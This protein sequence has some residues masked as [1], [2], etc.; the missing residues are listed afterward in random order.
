MPDGYWEG[1]LG[2]VRALVSAQGAKLSAT[3]ST[4]NSRVILAFTALG[5]DATAVAG[6]DLVAPLADMDWVTRQG[7]NGAIF[8]LI[9]ANSGGYTIPAD[10][11]VT[12]QT[13][14][15]KLIAF[16]LDRELGKGTAAAGGWALSGTDPD[17]DITAMALQSLAPYYGQ[18]GYVDLTQAVDRALIRLSGMQLAD[19]GFA[20]TDF[21]GGAPCCESAAQ[22]VIALTAL[23]VDPT[24][25]ARFVKAGG[26]PMTALLGFYQESTGAFEHDASGGGENLMAT[27]QAMLALT[28]YDRLHAGEPA[29]Y[30][31]TD[32]T[33]P[34]TRI[35]DIPVVGQPMTPSTSVDLPTRIEF[36]DGTARDV[37]WTSSATSVAGIRG[38]SLLTCLDE[39]TATLTATDV[40]GSGRSAEIAVTVARAVTGLRTPLAKIYLVRGTRDWKPFV[41]A[42]SVTNGT[43]G[44]SAKLAFSSSRPDVATVSA[45]TGKITALMTGST[46]VTA[47]AMNGKS[48]SISVTVTA[49]RTVLRSFGLSGLPASLKAGKT[50][51]LK[52]KPGPAS[53]TNLKTTF[54]SSNTR[55]ATIDAAGRVR[56]LK[57]GSARVTVTLAGKKLVKNL[58]VK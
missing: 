24:A 42:D 2:R 6:K 56:A 34:A 26:T 53:A 21:A 9:A 4:E 50:A 17:P 10:A 35:A 20:A 54:K 30:D 52:L 51:Q 43:A 22:V 11:G 12:N 46:T 36:A 39:G 8:A 47:Q 57:K 41:A 31:M 55:V 18:A 58:T 27:E 5:R 13:T 49:R 29:L 3:K 14:E 48:L 7:I 15:A 45:T 37:A 25:D 44:I 33:A 16:I 1:Y 19:G 28:A 23:G 32:A 40:D 38:G